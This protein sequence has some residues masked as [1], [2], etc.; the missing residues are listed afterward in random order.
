VWGNRLILIAELNNKWGSNLY[1]NCSLISNF[2]LLIP[3]PTNQISMKN[4]QSHQSIWI[5]P[6]K[7]TFWPCSQKKNGFQILFE[8]LLYFHEP[9]EK[10]FWT[11]TVCHTD[12]VRC[13]GCADQPVKMRRFDP[14]WQT[15]LFRSY[16]PPPSSDGAQY[17]CNLQPSAWAFRACVGS[18]VKLPP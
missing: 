10:G 17:W 2:H 8:I 14:H 9:C 7:V 11:Y 6:A 18:H 5:F 4:R 12:S 13:Q 1:Q 3:E 15:S 16:T